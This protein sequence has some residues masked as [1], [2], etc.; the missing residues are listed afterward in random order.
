MFVFVCVCVCVCVC[1]WCLQLPEKEVVTLMDAT[2]NVHHL[3]VSKSGFELGPQKSVQ[4]GNTCTCAVYMYMYALWSCA[5]NAE[6]PDCY[7]VE[8]RGAGRG[9]H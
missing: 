7:D 9:G 2:A 4:V 5:D 6:L 3:I 8:R 1:V